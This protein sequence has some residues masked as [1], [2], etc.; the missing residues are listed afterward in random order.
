LKITTL[1]AASL[2]A[3]PFTIGMAQ[4]TQAASV[5]CPISAQIGAGFLTS[6]AAKDATTTTG[7]HGGLSVSM[8]NKGLLGLTSKPSIDLDYNSNSGHGNHV[9]VF[10]LGY[11][12]RVM[13]SPAGAAIS[14]TGHH[15]VPYV[16]LG[17][18][19]FRNDVRRSETTTTSSNTGS[20]TVTT[21]STTHASKTDWRVGGKL[22]AGV[23]FDKTFIEASYDISGTTDGVRTDVVN[24]ALGLHF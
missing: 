13:L 3:V 12:E 8:Q 17:I 19:A 16:G 2:I 18:G 21:T 20:T 15:A 7:I 5:P 11:S 24:L 14:A 6:S 22:I 1:K 9:D 23:D 4:S 10:G